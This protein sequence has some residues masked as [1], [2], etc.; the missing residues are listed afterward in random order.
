MEWNELQVYIVEREGERRPQAEGVWLVHE[1]G[2]V[3][4]YQLTLAP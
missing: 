3:C 1:Y 2:Y 4:V